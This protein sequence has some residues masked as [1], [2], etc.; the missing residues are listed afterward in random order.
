MIIAQQVQRPMQRELA[1]FAN[2]AMPKGFGLTPGAV[3]GD[4]DLAQKES[5]RGEFVAIR[6]RKH[7]GRS[8]D[9]EEPAVQLANGLVT[10]ENDVNLGILIT[11]SAQTAVDHSP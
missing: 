2:L 9:A 11:E 3:E 4:H 6:K 1:Q 8:V 7:V 10:S 5:S